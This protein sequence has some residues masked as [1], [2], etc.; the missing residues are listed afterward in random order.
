[1]TKQ[2]RREREKHSRKNGKQESGICKNI[3]KRMKYSFLYATP[4]PRSSPRF[5]STVQSLPLSNFP[6]LLSLRSLFQILILLRLDPVSTNFFIVGSVFRPR[7]D[8][9]PFP[10]YS[11]SSSSSNCFPSHT[12]KT[13]N[14][15][16]HKSS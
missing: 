16:T 9:T 1:M 4:R 5:I 13:Q 12:H 14:P 7:F 2:E 3:I 15:P 11:S 6:H 8:K 10:I